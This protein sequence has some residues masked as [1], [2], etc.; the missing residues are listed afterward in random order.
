[1]MFSGLPRA[2][3]QTRPRTPGGIPRKASERTRAVDRFFFHA[4]RIEPSHSSH[5]ADWPSSQTARSSGVI[6]RPARAADDATDDE[7]DADDFQYADDRDE[8]LRDADAVVLTADAVDCRLDFL[9]ARQ[10]FFSRDDA[11]DSTALDDWLRA[12]LGGAPLGGTCSPSPSPPPSPSLSPPPSPSLSPPPSHSLSPPPSHS[13]PPPSPSP[14]LSPPPSLASSSSPSSSAE[15]C[16]R[17]AGTDVR[18]AWLA[19][20]GASRSLP[21]TSPPSPP[22]S[23][24]LSERNL[25]SVKI[26]GDLR[27]GSALGH[28]RP[29]GA[30]PVR[31]PSALAP[32]PPPAA[33]AALGGIGGDRGRR[34]GEA[35]DDDDDDDEPDVDADAEADTESGSESGSAAASVPAAVAASAEA[36]AAPVV[37]EVTS[38]SS[39]LALSP[40][41]NA[42]LM[43]GDVAARVVGGGG[44]GVPSDADDASHASDAAAIVARQTMLAVGKA[45]FAGGGAE[46]WVDS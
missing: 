5:K 8:T 34:H 7:D 20:H 42:A 38:P 35:A 28:R 25:P 23:L 15:R 46:G 41:S 44:D 16:P 19:H 37:E 21:P 1:V 45:P 12:C 32:P 36:P 40:A 6:G 27:L 17:A 3:F 24:S 22:S 26:A 30:T 39:S 29:L 43:D 2:T 11:E 9:T 31:C 14:S 13:L 33:E 10:P 18:T 4:G